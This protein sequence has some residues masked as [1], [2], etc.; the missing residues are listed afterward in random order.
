MVEV[1]NKIRAEE[2]TQDGLGRIRRFWGTFAQDRA[3]L[4][5]LIFLV[6]VVLVAIAAP[7][8]SPHDPYEAERLARNKPPLTDGYLLGTDS[9]GRDILT[10]LFYGG[11]ISLLVGFLPTFMAM[12][13]PRQ[14][15]RPVTP[16]LA[17]PLAPLAR[18]HCPTPCSATRFS[19]GFSRSARTSFRPSCRS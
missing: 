2:E 18:A 12:M 9:N 15:S 11:R 4:I 14:C 1:H 3:A 13:G 17:R 5:S 8:I 7:Y 19:R 6:A 10:R 16:S